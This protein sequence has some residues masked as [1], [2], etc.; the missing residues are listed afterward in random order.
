MPAPQ[1][2]PVR[3]P[4]HRCCKDAQARGSAQRPLWSGQDMDGGLRV[5]QD[6]WTLEKGRCQSPSLQLDFRGN[7]GYSSLK[8]L[9]AQL[10]PTL[11]N[12]MGPCPLSMGFSS[13]NTAVGNHSNL[14]GIFLTQG[15]NLGCIAGRFFIIWAIR[16][17]LQEFECLR[18]GGTVQAKEQAVGHMGRRHKPR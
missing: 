2:R 10:C 17:A 15:W 12:P 5:H 11:C 18:A 3:G 13:K 6:R 1:G 4:G 8:V 9:V 16:K 7:Q 14:Q